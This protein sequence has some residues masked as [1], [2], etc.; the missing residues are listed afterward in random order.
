[1]GA[2][3]SRGHSPATRTGR[4]QQGLGGPS[5]P[6]VARSRLRSARLLSLVFLCRTVGPAG[7]RGTHGLHR[8]DRGKERRRRATVDA[9]RGGAGE[10]RDA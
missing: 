4:S 1:M 3:R 2:A 6:R 5:D 7:S 8:G 10:D 9:S